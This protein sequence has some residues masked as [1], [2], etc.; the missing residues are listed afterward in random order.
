MRDRCLYCITLLEPCMGA[1]GVCPEC[2]VIWTDDFYKEVRENP[3]PKCGF[4]KLRIR[5]GALDYSCSE[6]NH[7]WYPGDATYEEIPS[8]GIL[9]TS[10]INWAAVMGKVE[11]EMKFADKKHGTMEDPEEGWFTAECE[12]TEWKKEVFKR[13]QNPEAAEKECIQLI[14]MGMKW[15]RDCLPMMKEAKERKNGDH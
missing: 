6:C 12:F 9:K 11:K 10:P 1:M 15:L 13:N 3:C 4:T 7:Q 14:A 2:K 8:D 5:P